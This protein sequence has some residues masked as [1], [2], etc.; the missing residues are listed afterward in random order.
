MGWKSAMEDARKRHRPSLENWER[1]GVY[2]AFRLFLDSLMAPE[3]QH[4]AL[5]APGAPHPRVLPAMLDGSELTYEEFASVYEAHGIP[6][7]ISKIPETEGWA[8]AERW[9]LENLEQDRD[10]LERKFKCGEDDDG[11]SIKVRLKHFL[12]YLHNNRDDSP[13]YIFDS[14]F[15]DDRVASRILSKY[16]Y[17]V[18][19]MRLFENDSYSDFSG[20]S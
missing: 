19:R 18:R 12:R 7:V 6:C 16:N 5:I 11:H 17:G 4:E 3:H 1:D 15:D 14:G 10:L 2:L 20:H 9:Q 13:L 8:A